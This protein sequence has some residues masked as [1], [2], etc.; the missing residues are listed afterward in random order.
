MLKKEVPLAHCGG[1]FGE[2]NI[3]EREM[4]RRSNS[5]S[6]RLA[7]LEGPK[8]IREVLD[9]PRFHFPFSILFLIA[10]QFQ[11]PFSISFLYALR[12][13]MRN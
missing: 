9:F 5:M 6:Q 8:I 7:I 2:S 13:E 3:T 4:H 12:C 11:G 1:C 10:Q